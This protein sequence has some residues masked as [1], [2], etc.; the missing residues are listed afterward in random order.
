MMKTPTILAA[1]AL[2]VALFGATPLGHA[3]SRIILPK[4]SVGAAQLKKA[5]VTGAKVKDGS[6]S[7]AD[8]M[9]GQLPAGE[10]GPK[11]DK[12]D[13]GAKG[14]TGAQG[15]PGLSGYQ[16]VIGPQ[17]TIPA[18][19]WA[20]A[21]ATCPAGKMA[22]G[23]GFSTLTGELMASAPTPNGTQWIAQVR[24]PGVGGPIL[25]VAV[26]TCAAVA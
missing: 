6:L 10:R 4:N 23:G 25:A 13:P 21:T 15:A 3:A 19:S 5:A 14:D 24:N 17:V 2:A 12:G 9:P 7:A 22:I 11:G 18:G 8:F 26:A 1:T 20:L 16:I